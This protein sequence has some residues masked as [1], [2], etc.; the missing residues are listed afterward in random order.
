[1]EAKKCLSGFVC[2]FKSL[3]FS[4]ICYIAIDIR[5]L[6]TGVLFDVFCGLSNILF[7][8]SLIF[9]VAKSNSEQSR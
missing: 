3:Y 2:V 6:F 1:M 5:D 4:H 8:D 7:H 9:D